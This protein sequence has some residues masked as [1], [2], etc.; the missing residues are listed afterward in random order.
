MILLAMSSF[1]FWPLLLTAIVLGFFLVFA[2]AVWLSGP[3][4]GFNHVLVYTVGVLLL[5]IT[6]VAWLVSGLIALFTS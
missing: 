5:I 3:G 6:I 4:D 2:F 1:V